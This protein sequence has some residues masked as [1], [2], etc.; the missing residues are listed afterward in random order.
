MRRPILVLACAVPLAATA[1]S[2]DKEG[3]PAPAPTA[4][5]SETP[6]APAPVPTATVTR[7]A[8]PAPAPDAAS[9]RDAEAAR[10]AQAPLQKTIP[11]RFHGTF[12]EDLRACAQPSHG[13][14][15]VRAGEIK[16]FESTGVVRN[17][18]A[19]GDYAAATVFE[20]YGDSPGTTYAFYMRLMPDGRLRYS[21][22]GYERLTWVRCP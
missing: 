6:P 8:T 21:Y 11:A 14:F 2:P 3:A 4:T 19:D 12:A 7:T 9:D 20:Q 1:C 13:M 22:D 10:T 17:V 15:T 5:L 16:F 18:R